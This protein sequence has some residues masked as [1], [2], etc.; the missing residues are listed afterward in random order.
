MAR[1]VLSLPVHPWLTED[2]VDT[3]VREV[4]KVLA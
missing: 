1:E 2:D 3:V 4:R